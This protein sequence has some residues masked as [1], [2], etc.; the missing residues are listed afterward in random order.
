VVVTTST[1]TDTLVLSHNRANT[2]TPLYTG[3]ATFAGTMV[4]PL[5]GCTETMA[6]ALTG[7][8]CGDKPYAAA[9]PT[10]A[11]QFI[12]PWFGGGT[13]NETIAYNY[14][15]NGLAS[16][17]S[18]PL[19]TSSTCSQT[20]N[21]TCR[22]IINYE[23]HISPIW[24]V[25]RGAVSATFPLG[26]D[27]CVSCHTRVVTP[28]RQTTI[29]CTPTGTT[30]A[31][32]VIINLG[33]AGGLELDATAPET[34]AGRFGSYDQLIKGSTNEPTFNAATDFDT[35]TCIQASDITGSA[36]V[37]LHAGSALGSG[38]SFFNK[39]AT[40]GSHAGRLTA[41][42]LRLLSEWVDVGAQYY[43]NPFS[44]PLAN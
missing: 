44:A 43:N 33:P 15:S 40:G 3:A 30:T 12:D 29:N 11:V 34:V 21:Y 17:L 8:N 20:W 18:T 36:P 24:F 9:T 26:A 16:G 25:T 13:G 31:M 1:G 10:M 37:S 35:S 41:A 7:V 28:A 2:F 5:A 39:F 23:T 19:P 4:Q 14:T 27:T 22:S 32:D 6:E 38:A 42:E